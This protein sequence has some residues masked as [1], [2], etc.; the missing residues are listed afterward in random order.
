[1][2]RGIDQVDLILFSLVLIDHAYST[3]FDGDTLLALQIH[4]VEQLF[5]HF[6]LRDC[7]SHLEQAIGKGAFAVVDMGDN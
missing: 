7:A 2:T 4:G 1:M 3:G 6:T 5:F